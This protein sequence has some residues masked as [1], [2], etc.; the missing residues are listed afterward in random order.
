[1]AYKPLVNKN[2]K[3]ELLL[4]TGKHF[5]HNELD[6][7]HVEDIIKAGKVEPSDKEGWDILVDGKFYFK[8]K[9]NKKPKDEPK[10]EDVLQ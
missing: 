9:K 3:V 4:K 7:K 2:G 5:S 10:D 1:M 8:V 6:P